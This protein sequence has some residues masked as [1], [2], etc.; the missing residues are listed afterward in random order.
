MNDNNSPGSIYFDFKRN[1]LP[2]LIAHER[3]TP[4]YSKKTINNTLHL[5]R[6]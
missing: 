2:C 3:Y 4:D 6:I 5:H 1:L